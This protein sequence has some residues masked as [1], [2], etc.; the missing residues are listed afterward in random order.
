MVLST[1][2]I[3][4]LTHKLCFTVS[5][6]Q[7]LVCQSKVGI[8]LNYHFWHVVTKYCTCNR[9]TKERDAVYVNRIH[10][11][12]FTFFLYDYTNVSRKYVSN[13]YNDLYIHN[14]LLLPSSS[15]DSCCQYHLGTK[16]RAHVNQWKQIKLLQT[17]HNHKTCM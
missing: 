16:T 7:Q 15:R 2:S 10:Y 5:P 13:K 17:T 14:N 1:T 11:L 3:P 4:S 9:F 8:L 6:S 12:L